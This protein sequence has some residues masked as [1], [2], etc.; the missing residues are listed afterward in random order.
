MDRCFVCDKKLGKQPFLVDTRD[1]QKVLVG[2]DC[3]KKIV[4]AGPDG[5]LAWPDM[6]HT[7]TLR[8]YVIECECPSTCDCQNP[9]KGL[10]SNECPTHNYSPQ[11]NPTCPA[12]GFDFPKGQGNSYAP[13]GINRKPGT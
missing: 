1:G 10:M 5:I 2:R 12:H 3:Y 13:F 7:F 9:D 6:A 4:E 11:V 8:L